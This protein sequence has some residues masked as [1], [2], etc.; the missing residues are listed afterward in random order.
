LAQVTDYEQILT[1]SSSKSFTRGLNYRQRTIYPNAARP[2]GW[3][4][5]VGI[6]RLLEEI[7]LQATARIDRRQ[8]ILYQASIDPPHMRPPSTNGYA[9]A[10]FC[11]DLIP[12]TLSEAM[13]VLRH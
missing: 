10:D 13:V 4:Q 12:V 11:Q 2:D 5:M 3:Q 6:D 9:T 1:G 7:R 8:P